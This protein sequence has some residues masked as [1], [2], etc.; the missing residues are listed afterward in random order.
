MQAPLKIQ[1]HPE[2]GHQ[3]LEFSKGCGTFSKGAIWAAY[4][5]GPAPPITGL[6]HKLSSVFMLFSVAMHSHL[7][8]AH[9]WKFGAAAV[10]LFLVVKLNSHTVSISIGGLRSKLSTY[11]SI[12]DVVY[13]PSGHGSDI[14]GFIP[15]GT[16]LNEYCERYHWEPFMPRV[17]RR[18]IFDLILINTELEWLEIRMGEMASEVDFF[19]VVESAMTFSD[20]PKPLYVRENWDRLVAYHNKIVLYTLNNTSQ[21]FPDAWSRESFSR[22]AM[23]EQVFPSLAKDERTAPNPGDVIIVGD[24]D[25]IVRPSVLTVLRNCAFP[26]RLRLH[27]KIYYYSF[28]WLSQGRGHGDWDHPDATFYTNYETT[29]RPQ[30]LRDDPTEEEIWNAGWHCSFC[31]PNLADIVKKITSFS[32]TE[33]NR[34]EIVDPRNIL[35]RVRMGLDI[36]ARGGADCHRVEGNADVPAFLQMNKQRFAYALDRDPAHGNFIDFADILGE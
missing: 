8:T 12:Y 36:F 22:N 18:K 14:N 21:I 13:S 16:S 2:E 34:P 23:F 15:E 11:S 3:I 6:S 20:A 28:Q 4:L 25:E 26:T 5:A 27:T 17:Q 1:T 29:I 9:G 7:F 32:H 30:S 24:V 31:L 19:V 33:M 35:R 10:F